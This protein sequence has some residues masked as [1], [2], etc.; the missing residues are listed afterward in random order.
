MATLRQVAML[1]GVS[2]ATV[3]HVLNGNYKVSPKLLARVMRVV[4]DVN[5]QPND[6]ARSLKTNRSKT[7]GMVVTDM[8]NPFYGATVR[9]AEDV[10][11][12]EG[13][14]LLVGNSGEDYS[15]E[16]SYY[17]IFKAKRAEGLIIVTCPTPYPPSYLLRHVMEEIPIVI[18]NRDYPGLQADTVV[19]DNL[20]GSYQAVRHLLLAGHRR[21]GIITGQR[22]N[23]ASARRLQGYE[24]ALINC[25]VKYEEELIQEGDFSNPRTG[26]DAAMKLCTMKNRPSALFVC[27]VRMTMGALK[28]IHE[29]GMK[30]PTEL[31]LVS[32]DDEEWFE[33]LSPRI[34]GVAQPA[35]DLGVRAAE[36]VMD[37]LKGKLPKSPCRK[38][39]KTELKV[40][41]SSNIQFSGDGVAVGLSKGVL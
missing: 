15:K 10:L 39:L 20:D 9:G 25:Q 13:Y 38:V 21:I 29:L 24:R 27:N 40:R 36:I 7:I 3:S 17:N 18:L 37:R 26:Y 4:K 41:E 32:F 12:R 14:T 23:I 30:V 8:T 6:F 31:A 33:L 28:A 19:S 34:S 5:Y 1:A 22:D 16:Q 35:Y 11:A 2:T